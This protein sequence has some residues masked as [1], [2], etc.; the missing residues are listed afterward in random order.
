M[1]ERRSVVAAEDIVTPWTPDRM[2]TRLGG[3]D[4]L[5]RQLAALFLEECPQMLERVRE[6]LQQTDPDVVRRAAHAFKGSVANFVDGGAAASALELETIGRDNRLS[7][8]PPVLERLEREI[9]TLL[10]DLRQ[11]AE[12][13]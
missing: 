4:A 12:G 8:A 11:F 9:A 3:D 13:A 5:A 6:S 10:V 1:S 2:V 7:E